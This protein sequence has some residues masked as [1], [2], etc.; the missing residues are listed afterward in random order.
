MKTKVVLVLAALLVVAGVSSTELHAQ[1]NLTFRFMAANISSG[2]GQSYEAEGI[3][4]FQGLKPDVVAIQEFQ[5]AGNSSSN[6]LRTLV[7]T[8]FGTDFNFYVEPSTG[9]PNGI[10]S[11]W[12]I[13]NAG[14]WDDPLIS[15]RNFAWAQIDLPGS[16]DLYVVSVH[17]YSSGSAADRNTEA[18]VIKT[19]IQFFFPANAWVVVGGDMNTSSRGEAAIGTFGTFLSDAPIPTDAETGGD[20]DTNAGRSSPYDY[21]LPSFSFTNKL[22]PVTFAAHTFTK[23]LVFDSRVYSPLSDVSPVLAGDSGVTGMQH[24]AVV[25]DF[26]ITVE[27]GSLTNP[28][29]ITV[30]PL[31]QTNNVGANISFTVTASG[32]APLAYQWRFF[33]T[34]LLGSTATSH[35]ITNIQLTNAGNYTVVVTNAFGSITSA[36]ATLTVNAFSAPTIAT[37]PQSQTVTVGANATF[38]VVANG[39]APLSYQWRFGNAAISAATNASYTRSNAQLVDAGNYTVVITN[40][41]GSITSSPAVLTVNSV[42]TGNVIAQWNFN[43]LPPDG[44]LTTGSTNAAI[45]SGT[46][47]LFGGA[48]ATF[49]TGDTTL[50]PAGS[51]DNTAWN[52]AT[53]P[54]Q[55]A[56]N[57]TRGAQFSV[58]TVGKQSISVT[59]THRLSSTASKYSRLQYTTN[60]TDYIDFPTPVTLTADS[61][62]ER[63]TN[64]LAGVA[65]VNN[66][67][68]FAFRIVSEFESTA[69]GN[70]NA[71]YVT[72]GAG[73]Y[74][75]GGTHRLDMVTVLGSNLVV[76]NPPAITPTLT[77]LVFAGGQF[78]FLLTGTVSS[79]Y[80]V[81][82]TTNISPVN[83]ISVRTNAA[84]FTFVETN[85][86]N[87]PQRFYRG[88]I[89][90]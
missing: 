7:D 63:K 77:N 45:G 25:K 2:T 3:R 42:V 79:N 18:T 47:L 71:N 46:A 76:T 50:D 88:M 23:G 31:S 33:A 14:F 78:Q 68:N 81:Q 37:N 9:I 43:S 20:P 87:L 41:V 40:S 24:M 64:S 67:A 8:A 83:W 80:I 11:R 17:L 35:S 16:N 5:V 89:A 84:P 49:A 62:F 70:A 4:I 59:W 12:P 51:T 90:P 15:D 72:A 60:G 52:V 38:T 36:V 73:A 65:S 44:V 29:S 85:A 74:G 22:V 56:G 34:N 86:I 55:G 69:I 19:N 58:S 53:F 30:Q 28:P 13:I 27:D 82:A 10:V 75:V 6:T 32:T 1:S 54:A 39:S 48:T 21:V 57:K 61:V 66:N 26:Q